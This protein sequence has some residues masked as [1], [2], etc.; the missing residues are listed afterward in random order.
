M[1]PRYMAGFY[2][3]T[4]PCDKFAGQKGI[5]RSYQTGPVTDAQTLP[6]AG[7]CGGHTGSHK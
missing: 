5:N 6:I 4:V 2:P 1:K 3:L 7:H